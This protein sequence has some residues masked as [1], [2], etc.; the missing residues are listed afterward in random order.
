MPDDLLADEV[1]SAEIVVEIMPVPVLIDQIMRAGASGRRGFV[2]T[3]HIGV[4]FCLHDEFFQHVTPLK[5]EHKVNIC[6]LR[7]GRK[8]LPCCASR[9]IFEDSGLGNRGVYP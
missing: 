3:A 5:K 2:A 9:H 4:G 7:D 6:E 1:G 8:R